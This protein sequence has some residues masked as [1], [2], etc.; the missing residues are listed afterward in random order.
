MRPG[1]RVRLNTP[2]NP[3]LDGAVGRVARLTSYLD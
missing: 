3:R 2:D 1:Q